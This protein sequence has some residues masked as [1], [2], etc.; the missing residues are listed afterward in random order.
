MK[1]VLSAL[2]L[3]ILLMTLSACEHNVS[4]ETTVY[5]D[6]SID[7]AIILETADTTQNFLGIG[8]ENGWKLTTH[9]IEDTDS[10]K[11]NESKKWKAKYERTFT[12]AQQ[13]TEELA[14]PS[15]SLFRVSSK[16][17]KNFKWFYTYLFYSDT[18]HAINRMS[19][20]MDDYLT[21]EDFAFID[22]LPAEGQVITKADSLYLSRLQEKIFDIYGLRAIYESY[23]R[24]NEKLIRE[25]GL[26][27]RWLDTLKKHKENLYHQLADKKD[28]P[29]DF[30]Y[31]AMDSLG[32][33]FPYDKMS[34]RYD[35]LY[36]R[37]DA[38]T[39]FINHAS[40][41]K[42]THIINMPWDVVRTNAD[43][44]S[45]K[46]LQWNPPSIKFLLK[47][48]TMYAESRKINLWAI[49]VS[50][51]VVVLSAYLFWRRIKQN[52]ESKPW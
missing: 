42:Y 28:L 37:E 29:E 35:E 26:E 45:D 38:V 4:M 16:F 40:E 46:R 23:Y 51:A 12:S 2:L 14:R 9:L 10:V 47:D 44:I 19:Y 33:P 48:Y 11:K 30:I 21:R 49:L 6:G 31:K 41:G 8:V 27:E 7:K 43:S 24:M 50:V 52:R 1:I 3:A 17:E 22:R 18:Y 25:S 34:N 15:D 20:P 39:T 36:Q 5:E 32:I 13:A